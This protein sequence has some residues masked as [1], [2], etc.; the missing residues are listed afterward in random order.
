MTHDRLVDDVRGREGGTDPGRQQKLEPMR[1]ALRRMICRS[2]Y[3]PA[4][5]NVAKRE[6]ALAR[7]GSNAQ[8][9]TAARR[10]LLPALPRE[11]RA[12]RIVRA[13]G[14][15]HRFVIAAE[16]DESDRSVLDPANFAI[17]TEEAKATVTVFKDAH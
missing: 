4:D 2:R 1:R 11:P 3:Q 9:T 7:F 8:S 12:E 10:C 16:S 5:G 15:G 13:R 17:V 14:R 6:L